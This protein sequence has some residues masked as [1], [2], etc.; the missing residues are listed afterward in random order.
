M[1]GILKDPEH[2]DYEHYFEWL[3]CEFDPEE[4]DLEKV[5]GLFE[6]T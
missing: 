6:M 2:G 4:F 1:L 5:D 3:G